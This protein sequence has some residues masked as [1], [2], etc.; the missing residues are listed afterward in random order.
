MTS[1]LATRVK[2]SP[3]FRNIVV[4]LYS[5]VSVRY[6]LQG[7]SAP[8]PVVCRE[9]LFLRLSTTTLQDASVVADGLVKGE[10]SVQKN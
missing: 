9:Q 6:D 7:Y 2:D 4:L 5:K 1:S 8:I 10:K 3:W